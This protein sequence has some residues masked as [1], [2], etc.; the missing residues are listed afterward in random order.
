M[1]RFDCWL[2]ACASL[3]WEGGMW[4]K[5]GPRLSVV[6]GA[7]VAVHGTAAERAG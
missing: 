6:M 5:M 3:P 7:W 2:H 4:A 1:V